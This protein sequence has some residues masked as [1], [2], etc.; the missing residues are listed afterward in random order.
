MLVLIK[1]DYGKKLS[2]LIEPYAELIRLK[3]YDF[4]NGHI[5]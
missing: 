2:P 5:I 3:I 1:R 4:S